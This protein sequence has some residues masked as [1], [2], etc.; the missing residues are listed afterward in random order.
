MRTE[1]PHRDITMHELPVGGNIMGIVFAV[2]SVLIFLL[3]IPA[4]WFVTLAAIAVGF[5]V[6]GILRMLDVKPEEP[7]SILSADSFARV[8]K[9]ARGAIHITHA[10]W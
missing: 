8:Q 6:V 5:A 2:G 4:L 10:D 9:H 3:A 7:L 1:I